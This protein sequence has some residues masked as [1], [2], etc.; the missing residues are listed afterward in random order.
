[1]V[2]GRVMKKS[3]QNL[4]L[5]LGTLFFDEF[6][7]VRIISFLCKVADTCDRLKISEYETYLPI[8]HF[9]KDDARTFFDAAVGAANVSEGEMSELAVR[10]GIPP[11][12]VC[13]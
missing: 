13:H 1:M 10:D 4:G 6:D 8:I 2:D 12:E 9:L 11:Q 7:P 5:H 3:L